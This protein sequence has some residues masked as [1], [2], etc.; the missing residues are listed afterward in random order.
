LS[1]V[2]SEELDRFGISFDREFESC[3]D[4]TTKYLHPLEKDTRKQDHW[5]WMC[6][7]GPLRTGGV[8]LEIPLDSTL[9]LNKNLSLLD[10]PKTYTF[11]LY[12]YLW[13]KCCDSE[14]RGGWLVLVWGRNRISSR[15]SIDPSFHLRLLPSTSHHNCWCQFSLMRFI[16]IRAKLI[17]PQSAKC[18]F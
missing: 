5:L 2:K 7:L 14:S 18:I 12:I 17:Q 1:S 10:C 3:S 8:E 9:A 11:C 4:L 16:L 13:L 15:A 6:S